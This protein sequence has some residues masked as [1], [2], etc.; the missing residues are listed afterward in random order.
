MASDAIREALVL[1][2]SMVIA[3]EPMSDQATQKYLAA[4][5]A[6]D[7]AQ[8]PSDTIPCIEIV[9]DSCGADFLTRSAADAF[10]YGCE[11]TLC[12]SCTDAF[13]HIQG[14]A[15]GTGDPAEI[16]SSDDLAELADAKGAKDAAYRERNCLVAALS[17]LLPAY[18]ARHPD[19]DKEWEDDWRWI[20]FIES[21]RGQLSWHIH[22]SELPLFEHLEQVDDG[23][24]DGHTTEEKYARL[25]GLR[26]RPAYLEAHLAKYGRHTPACA[27]VRDFGVD[28]DGCDCGWNEVTASLR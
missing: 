16:A 1:L 3:K 28:E 13:G 12:Q 4:I 23:Q 26:C 10:C 18:M 19:E 15:H 5:A 8:P 27:Y 20:V 6:L 14:G 21:P 22:D 11:R 9:C 17:K 2:R 24:W 7:A 25:A